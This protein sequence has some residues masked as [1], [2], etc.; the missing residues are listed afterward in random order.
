MLL[1]LDL[2]HLYGVIIVKAT[3]FN[4]SLLISTRKS[5]M[6]TYYI[7]NNKKCAFNNAASEPKNICIDI[8][9]TLDLRFANRKD[10][11]KAFACRAFAHYSCLGNVNIMVVMQNRCKYL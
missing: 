1:A 11:M 4:Y 7:D 8:F 5:T 2:I 6:Y 10:H 9:T 3:K